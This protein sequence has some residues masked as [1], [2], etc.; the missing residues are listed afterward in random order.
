MFPSATLATSLGKV[1]VTATSNDHVSIIG[2]HTGTDDH[3]IVNGVRYHFHGH[4]CR[5]VTAARPFQ[6]QRRYYEPPVY[7]DNGEERFMEHGWASLRRTDNFKEGTEAAF[8]KVRS[9]IVEA[10]NAFLVTEEGKALLAQASEADY[11]SRLAGAERAYEEA[12]ETAERLRS[13]LRSIQAE[14]GG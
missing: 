5:Y 9:V 4:L 10:V 7:A 11:A 14:R 12:C 3:F 13:E 6:P 1:T 8:R 2:G